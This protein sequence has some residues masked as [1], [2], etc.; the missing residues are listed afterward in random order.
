MY[1]SRVVFLELPV[2]RGSA[3]AYSVLIGDI[4]KV[5]KVWE[6]P[7]ATPSPVRPA[8]GPDAC[9][10]ASGSCSQARPA[11]WASAGQHSEF[12]EARLLL[13]LLHEVILLGWGRPQTAFI[14]TNV[15]R[16]CTST[17]KGISRDIVPPAAGCPASH[18][19]DRISRWA[20]LTLSCWVMPD[21]RSTRHG[22][23]FYLGQTEAW[24]RCLGSILASPKISCVTL[25]KSLKLSVTQLPHL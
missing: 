24:G 2:R 6:G 4:T 25:S 14:S 18:C 12:N 22:P 13:S 11:E 15:T 23:G 10:G 7:A 9:L 1:S 3:A 17:A 16:R 5:D 8:Q 19:L 20:S 21:S